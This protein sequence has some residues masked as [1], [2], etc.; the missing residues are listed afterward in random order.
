LDKVVR[1]VLYP[2]NVKMPE[3]PKKGF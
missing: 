1:A 2:E 3:E